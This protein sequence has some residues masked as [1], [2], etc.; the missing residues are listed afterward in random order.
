M[1]SNHKRRSRSLS[2]VRRARHGSKERRR[3]ERSRSNSRSQ[4][5]SRN[6]KTRDNDQKRS[7]KSEPQVSNRGSR[8]EPRNQE[9]QSSKGFLVEL[10][11]DD[12]SVRPF[13]MTIAAHQMLS[14]LQK[15]VGAH[16]KDRKG[17]Q[18]EHDI[19][20]KT[21]KGKRLF[22]AMTAE[23]AGLHHGS[24]VTWECRDREKESMTAED[25]P[26]ETERAKRAR[27]EAQFGDGRVSDPCDDRG[28][29]RGATTQELE[30]S[31]Q[32]KTIDF[33]SSARGAR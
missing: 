3:R 9:E 10:E 30:E 31:S 23:E 16:C 27:L 24:V 33:V 22:G 19:K 28:F 8:A 29:W 32:D 17:Y 1:S 6:N 13:R 14:V 2:R 15:A 20:L 12:D 26:H 25:Q 21:D 18:G 5:R 7:R 4:D 11:T